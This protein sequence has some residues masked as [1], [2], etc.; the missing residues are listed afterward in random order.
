[1]TITLVTDAVDFREAH[2]LVSFEGLIVVHGIEFEPPHRRTPHKADRRRVCWLV[3]E[4]IYLLVEG[5]RGGRGHYLR[6]RLG[7]VHY[8]LQI[9]HHCAIRRRQE[10]LV[11]PPMRRTKHQKG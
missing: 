9:Q 1:M 3:A 6:K 5:D 4:E 11:A 8:R 7:A 10:T 2:D